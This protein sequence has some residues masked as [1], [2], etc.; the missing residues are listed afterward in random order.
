MFRCSKEGLQRRLAAFSRV[1]KALGYDDTFKLPPVYGDMTRQD[2]LIEGLRAGRITFEDDVGNNDT[3]FDYMTHI[4][5]L[6]NA[7][8]L[9]I[10]KFLFTPF[11][12]L[13]GTPEQVS[14]WLP[15]ANVGK[16]TGSYAQTE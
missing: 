11:L 5:V 3:I 8:P 13:V 6:S 16:I 9:G 1:Y 2:L 7:N 4:G 10:T 14:H 12:K 15:L